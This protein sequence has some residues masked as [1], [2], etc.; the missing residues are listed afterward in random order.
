MLSVR[1]FH[2]LVVPL[3]LCSVSPDRYARVKGDNTTERG[4]SQRGRAAT[5]RSDTG[6]TSAHNAS[7]APLLTLRHCQ[8]DKSSPFSVSV[9][10]FA[11]RA[12]RSLC[13]IWNPNFNLMLG[14]VFLAQSQGNDLLRVTEF[15]KTSSQVGGG[16][17]CGGESTYEVR[18]GYCQ[19][20]IMLMGWVLRQSI[21]NIVYN[22]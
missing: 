20:I 14:T 7:L 5:R 19:S 4:A 3:S 6:M 22:Y 16:R 12:G 13:F 2:S 21:C 10:V 9:P 1:C 8:G 17:V 15:L 11:N 18:T